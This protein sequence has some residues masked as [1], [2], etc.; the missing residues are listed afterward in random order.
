[1]PSFTDNAGKARMSIGT[2]APPADSLGFRG[3]HFTNQGS[4]HAVTDLGQARFHNTQ[5]L[6]TDEF[7]RLLVTPDLPVWTIPG[8]MRTNLNGALV[9]AD[10][11]PPA[12]I[13]QGFAMTDNGIVC[14]LLAS[15]WNASL[16]EILQQSL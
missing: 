12:V 6:V 13:N 9:V 1:M 2:G 15:P 8:G 14:L 16:A 4:V 5:A 11:A 7:G 3:L 10:L